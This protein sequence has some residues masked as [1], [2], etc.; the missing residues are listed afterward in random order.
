MV[1]NCNSLRPQ[2]IESQISEGKV[3]LFLVLYVFSVGG[4]KRA[5]FMCCDLTHPLVTWKRFTGRHLILNQCL[6]KTSRFPV[7]SPDVLAVHAYVFVHNWLAA[8]TCACVDKH[9]RCFFLKTKTAKFS[10]VWK[11]KRDHSIVVKMGQWVS[12]EF[13]TYS[14]ALWTAPLCSP[15]ILSPLGHVCSAAHGRF[16]TVYVWLGI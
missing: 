13:A 7:R 16:M 14:D 1:T 8:R 3:L 15:E 5:L 11:W 10:T 6:A 2:S 12:G 4:M 9:V